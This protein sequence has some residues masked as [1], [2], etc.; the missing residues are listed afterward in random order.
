MPE[1]SQSRIYPLPF[2]LHFVALLFFVAPHAAA[3]TE[4]FWEIGIEY[5]TSNIWV[6]LIVYLCF[7][8]VLP[9]GCAR[10]WTAHG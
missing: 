3:S 10:V 8:A 7:V 1:R 9:L 2:L 4:L 6:S 5:S